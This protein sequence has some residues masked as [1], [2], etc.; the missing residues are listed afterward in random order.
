MVSNAF[1]AAEE[2]QQCGLCPAKKIAF[3]HR[4]PTVELN[5]SASFFRNVT[6]SC[7]DLALGC[8]RV[9]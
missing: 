7:I 4:D 3:R 5:R 8:D 9:R 6:R 2:V 1:L